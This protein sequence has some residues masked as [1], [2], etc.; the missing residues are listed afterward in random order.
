MLG[1]CLPVKGLDEINAH[2]L[3]PA[4]EIYTFIFIATL[5]CR[6]YFKKVTKSKCVLMHTSGAVG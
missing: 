6:N 4:L 2:S 5:Y 3:Q 1:S